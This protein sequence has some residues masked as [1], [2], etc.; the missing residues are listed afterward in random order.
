MADCSFPKT[1]R[2]LNARDYQAVF[3][4]SRFKVSCRYILVLAANN[5]GA[6]SRLGIIVAKK[7]IG[8]AVARNRIKRL[9]REWFRCQNAFPIG[10]DL[11]VMVRKDADT[12][13]NSQFRQRLAEL[14]ADLEAK[15][16]PAPSH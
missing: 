1:N 12:L 3:S 6:H 4:H 2:L 15:C 13:S 8:K 5:G 9:L 16:T 14:W 11:V 10:L 7:H